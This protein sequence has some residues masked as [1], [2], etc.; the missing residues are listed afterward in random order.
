[1][2]FYDYTKPKVINPKY[3]TGYYKSQR[4]KA[5]T[6]TSNLSIS[7]YCLAVLDGDS[8]QEPEDEE[9][10]LNFAQ[11]TFNVIKD[12][13]TGFASQFKNED[14]SANSE[15]IQSFLIGTIGGLIA[16]KLLRLLIK[17]IATQLIKIGTKLAIKAALALQTGGAS[18]LTI[19]FDIIPMLELGT[20]MI[21]S[22][23]GIGADILIDKSL[24]KDILESAFNS[25]RD[26]LENNKELNCIKTYMVD[27]QISK[28]KNYNGLKKSEKK[29]FEKDMIKTVNNI[30]SSSNS[31]YKIINSKKLFNDDDRINNEQLRE[32]MPCMLDFDQDTNEPYST[33]KKI[34]YGCLYPGTEDIVDK[35][36]GE[37]GIFRAVGIPTS[38]CNIDYINS[39]NKFYN[40]PDISKRNYDYPVDQNGVYKGIKLENF[41]NYEMSKPIEIYDPNINSSSLKETDNCVSNFTNCKKGDKYTCNQCLKVPKLS[42]L[43]LKPTQVS[44]A[45]TYNPD[46]NYNNYIK[47]GNI[48][49]KYGSVMLNLKKSNVNNVTYSYRS[50][51]PFIFI[52]FIII[53]IILYFYIKQYNA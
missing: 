22:L 28:N 1:M 2:Q 14:G 42:I 29:Q 11:K 15:G 50:I 31:L 30:L 16:E 12:F 21:R 32:C 51:F 7:P 43:K 20:M 38:K 41:K 25:Y 37:K 27:Y 5:T 33:E 40:D 26:T 45:S 9:K 44:L 24:T 36:S 6:G 4:L 35:Q 48:Q 10:A 39:Y 52:L 46:N 34:E 3:K 17:Y 18:L 47:Q 19:I 13:A 53:F 23:G 8:I 49:T